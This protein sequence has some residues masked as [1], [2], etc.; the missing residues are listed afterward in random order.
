MRIENT[1]MTKLAR[2]LFGINEA[3]TIQNRHYDGDHWY[4]ASNICG[5]LG[6]AGYSQA[7]HNPRFTDN[8]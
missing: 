1:N 4:M 7:V 5:L 8:R 6:I 3:Q 2:F